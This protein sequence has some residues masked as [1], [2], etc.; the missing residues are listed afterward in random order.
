MG[1]CDNRRII[2]WELPT[3]IEERQVEQAVMAKIVWQYH[4]LKEVNMQ[5]I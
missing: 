5:I 3:T 2:H 1:V 4:M